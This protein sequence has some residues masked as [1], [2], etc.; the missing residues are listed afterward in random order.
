MMQKEARGIQVLLLCVFTVMLGLGIIGPIIPIYAKSMGAT[1]S[2]IG[3]LGSIWSLSRLI[4]TPF[5]GRLS[6][7][8]GRKKIIAV[9]LLAYAIVSVLYAAAWDYTSLLL[10]RFLHGLGSAMSIPIAMAYAAEVAPGGKEGRYMGNMNLAMF[11]G[12]G[13]GPLIGGYLGDN[14]S[15]SAPFYV[16]GAL[17]ALS[18][19]LLLILLPEGG[20]RK[21]GKIRP[22]FKMALKSSLIRAAFIYRAVMALGIGGT[23]GFMA[24]FISGPEEDGGLALS[25]SLAGL[26]MSFSQVS[27]ALLQRPF[28]VVADRYDKFRLVILGGMIGALGY[29]LLPLSRSLTSLVGFLLLTS[30]GNA[31][32]MPA[33]TALITIEGRDVGM[34]TTM[35][36]IEGAMS[37]GM[38]L[39]PLIYGFVVD[40]LGLRAAF[41]TTGIICICGTITFYLL[42]R[43]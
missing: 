29:S 38:I 24:L 2:E 22:S 1:Y 19:I 33:L 12:M 26:I 43:T 41:L 27:S 32:G 25:I 10:F 16:M 37:M 20:E 30:L 13:L 28:G 11:A 17:A 5:V 18:L 40:S 31:I 8:K 36:V 42:H 35:G 3:L 21:S 15:L 39:G 6:D 23:M 4:F 7:V 9:G 34:G 14:L